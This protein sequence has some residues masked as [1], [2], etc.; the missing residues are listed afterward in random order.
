M[1]F[2]SILAFLRKT[3]KCLGVPTWIIYSE[4]TISSIQYKK[5]ITRFQTSFL[6]A[7]SGDVLGWDFPLHPSNKAMATRVTRKKKLGSVSSDSR[8]MP[9][10]MY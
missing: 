3:F 1:L 7:S 9:T 8:S 2:A 6:A 5:M 10:K 4:V